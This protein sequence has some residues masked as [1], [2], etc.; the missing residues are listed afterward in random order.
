VPQNSAA[1]RGEKNRH[2]V[3]PLNFNNFT[4]QTMKEDRFNFIYQH[5]TFFKMNFLAILPAL[6]EEIAILK[7]G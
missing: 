2:Y 1:S 5:Q 4:R 6:D 7:S 3:S